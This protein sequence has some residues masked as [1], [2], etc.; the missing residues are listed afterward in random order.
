VIDPW[1][2]DGR[3]RLISSNERRGVA[4]A[5]NLAL[6]K[7]RGQ[8][9]C[10]LDADDVMPAGSLATRVKRF[11]EDPAL[12]FVDGIVMVASEDL[13]T[14]E[15]FWRPDFEGNPLSDLISLSGHSFFGCT[16][17]VR[18]D[19]LGTTRM[20]EGL[21]HSEDLLF[22][23]ELARKGGKYGFVDVPILTYRNRRGSAM[24]DLDGLSHGYQYILECLARWGDFEPEQV[25]A[26]RKRSQR[27]MFLSY[28]RK[29]R[30]GRALN[31]V[32][33]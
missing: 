31:V 7:V 16:W 24:K 11:H 25:S 6:E 33:S 1:L 21:S 12:A 5:R 10:F 32:V 13:T 28:L 18:A 15:R 27:I 3:V 30:F 23:I 19:M 4:A 9:F 26:Y 2:S 14:V 29:L 17:L 20:R 22:Y 8:Y